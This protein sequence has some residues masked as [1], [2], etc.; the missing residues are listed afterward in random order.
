MSSNGPMGRVTLG[1]LKAG[2]RVRYWEADSN[3]HAV[4]HEAVVVRARGRGVR[5]ERAWSTGLGEISSVQFRVNRSEISKV[6]P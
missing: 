1:R 2:M 4:L 5:I 3:G 6:L